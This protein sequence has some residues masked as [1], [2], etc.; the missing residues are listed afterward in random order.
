LPHRCRTTL[1]ADGTDAAIAITLTPKGTGALVVSSEIKL[2]I[3]ESDSEPTLDN[4]NGMV[5]WKDTD[6]SNAIYLVFRRG[7]GDQVAVELA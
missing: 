7:T 1:A 4:D 2:K 3:V 5:I 6:D